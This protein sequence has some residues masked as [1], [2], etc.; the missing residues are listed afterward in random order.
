MRLDRPCFYKRSTS[1]VVSQT[2]LWELVSR[3]FRGGMP[4]WRRAVGTAELLGR[5]GCWDGGLVRRGLLRQRIGSETERFGE[6]ELWGRDCLGRAGGQ[7]W[8]GVLLPGRLPSERGL[9]L[10]GRGF[11]RR[12]RLVF[13]R[14]DPGDARYACPN[15][16]RVAHAILPLCLDGDALIGNVGGGRLSGI[17]LREPLPFG[18]W[19]RRPS[20]NEPRLLLLV[21]RIPLKER[22][23]RRRRRP[24]FAS[25]RRSPF[26]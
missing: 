6:A 4:F 14:K 9:S 18:E 13:L 5:Q 17:V 15:D 11:R 26:L 3:S 25:L 2:W 21:L 24:F 12:T 8:S 23:R 19:R 7:V 10:G 20:L 16:S 22:L 1:D